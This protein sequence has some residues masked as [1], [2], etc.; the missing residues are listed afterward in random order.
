MN[1]KN[2]VIE[3]AQETMYASTNSGHIHAA[4]SAPALENDDSERVEAKVEQQRLQ[5][6]TLRAFHEISVLAE[7]AT[8]EPSAPLENDLVLPATTPT[9]PSLSPTTSKKLCRL[10]LPQ[11]NSEKSP[12]VARKS[13]NGAIS[14]NVATYS[15]GATDTNVSIL[16][17][18]EEASAAVRNSFSKS[19]LNEQK[20]TLY[21]SLPL[22]EHARDCIVER[23]END[24]NAKYKQLLR[25]NLTRVKLE[26]FVNYEMNLLRTEASQKR[27]EMKMRHIE[28]NKGE[29]YARL[30]RYLFSEYL[31]HMA[32]SSM[33]GL[34]RK[35]DV[36]LK[37]V[38]TLEK[39]RLTMSKRCGDHVAM[40]QQMEFQTAKLETLHLARLKSHLDQLRQLRT[41][42]ASI[43]TSDRAISY[44]QVEQYLTRVLQDPNL[45]AH[46]N[47][48]R[49]CCG[50][51]NGREDLDLVP[52][53]VNFYGGISHGS[54]LAAIVDHLKYCLDV[55]IFFEKKVTLEEEGV[56]SR[57]PQ[58]FYRGELIWQ[59]TQTKGHSSGMERKT[60]CYACGYINGEMKT[61]QWCKRCESCDV[62]LYIPPSSV[63]TKSSEW[64]SSVLRF[65]Q[66]LQKWISI[67]VQSL[68]R[69]TSLQNMPY[70][71]MHVM[72]LPRISTDERSWFLRFF[73]FPRA[74]VR[75]DGSL[76]NEWSEDLVDHYIAMLHLVFHPEK[77]RQMATIVSSK[78]SNATKAANSA[79]IGV[80]DKNGLVSP[81]WVLL[82][83]PTMLDR[84]FLSDEDFVAVLNQFP[85][86]FAFGQ[87]F[88]CTLDVKKSFSRALTL[89]HELT[90]SLRAFQEFEQLPTRIAQL[91]GQLL[92]EAAEVAG[93]GRAT[94]TISKEY[95]LYPTLFDQ[96]VLASL[97]GLMAV[98]CNR[99]AWRSLHLIPFGALSELAKWDVVALLL[100]NLNS[101]PHEAK[102]ASGW[103][104]FV[105]K[106]TSQDV[107]TRALVRQ[108]LY[109]LIDSD[110]ESSLCLLNA[111]ASIAASCTTQT[112][113]D[114]HDLVVVAVHEL[115]M[116]GFTVESCQQALGANG[117]RAAEPLSILCLAHPWVLS[118]LITLLYKFHKCAATWIHIFE[119]FPINRWMPTHQ[120]LV[121]LQEWLLLKDTSAPRSALA[122]FLL[123]HINWEYDVKMQRLFTDA[124]L[125]RQ[126]ALMVAEA[127]VLYKTRKE[128]A[129]DSESVMM[130]SGGISPQKLEVTSI[131]KS[132]RRA[133][134]F[135]ESVDFEKWCWKLMLKLRFYSPKEHEPLLPLIDL[136]HDRTREAL[137]LRRWFAGASVLRVLRSRKVLPFY[138]SH[139]DHIK[140]SGGTDKKEQDTVALESGR[141]T[142]VPI[143][144]ENRLLLTPNN[145]K[146]G[147]SD[148]TVSA[149]VASRT[150]P[151]VAY[152]I[153]QLTTFVFSDR[154]DRWEPLLVLLKSELFDAAI[155]V[156]ENIIPVLSRRGEMKNDLISQPDGSV[157]HSEKNEE[158]A[159]S[160][161]TKTEAGALLSDNAIAVELDYEVEV[162]MAA[163]QALSTDELLSLLDSLH[164]FSYIN[165][166]ELHRM[167]EVLK[168]GYIGG[169][170]ST[171][172]ARILAKL[173]FVRE[174]SRYLHPVVLPA[175]INEC[176]PQSSPVFVTTSALYHGA[177]SW[178][179]ST[180]GGE[181]STGALSPSA[182]SSTS[183][184]LLIRNSSLTATPAP[185]VFLSG[186]DYSMSTTS[187]C[188]FIRRSFEY[189]VD[190]SRLL[191]SMQFWAK[192]L[193]QVPFWYENA[194]FRHVLDVM[195]QCSMEKSFESS[196]LNKSVHDSDKSDLL[197]ELVALI[198]ATFDAF[199]QRIAR[200]EEARDP[201][202]QFLENESVVVMS[203]LPAATTSATFASIFRDTDDVA[204]YIGGCPYLS[205]WILLVETQKEV[206]LFLA[207]GQLMIK[208]EPKTMKKI[209]KMKRVKGKLA[210]A[211]GQYNAVE[212]EEKEQR[213]EALDGTSRLS[214]AFQFSHT[215]MDSL[216]QYKIYRWC[217]YCLDLPESEPLQI[218][219]WQVFFALYFAT[220]GS[221][222]V[223]GHHFLDHTGVRSPKHV[224]LRTCLQM[225]LRK[226]VSYC[227]NQAQVALTATG[228]S[229]HSQT[230]C[231][232]G[233]S[234][235]L[236]E[237][238]Y[239]H[240]VALSQLYTAMDA[241]MEER[242]PNMWLKEDNLTSLPRLY[243][244]ER[245]KEV[246]LLS[247]ALLCNSSHAITWS[248]LR[249]WT[250]LCGFEFTRRR[251]NPTIIGG[252][253]SSADTMAQSLT[254]PLA[255]VGEEDDFSF[256]EEA[257][258]YSKQ[259]H[260]FGGVY[261]LTS[262][263]IR[264]LPLLSDWCSSLCLTKLPTVSVTL[265]KDQCRL[266]PS[267]ALDHVGLNA[268][269]MKFSEN[270]STILALDSEL[271]ESVSQLYVSKA[272]TVMQNVPCH[273]GTQCRS[274]AAFK[275]E[276]LEWMMDPRMDDMILSI[277][278]QG[279]RCDLPSMVRPSEISS[280]SHHGDELHEN[281]DLALPASVTATEFLQLDGKYDVVLM[282]ILLIDQ[283]VRALGMELQRLKKMLEKEALVKT[284]AIEAHVDV[285]EQTRGAAVEEL[286][287]LQK[288]EQELKCLHSKGLE[289]FHLL[290]NLDTKL[291]RSVPSV[292]E[293]LWRSV[294]QLGR[295]FV[296]IDERETC[297]LLQLMLQDPSR[298]HLLSDCFC[299]SAAPS[300]FVEMFAMLMSPSNSSKLSSEQKLTLLYRFDFQTWLQ[301][302]TSQTQFKFDRDTILCI[303]LKDVR[304][305]F[306]ADRNLVE[307]AQKAKDTIVLDHL[308]QVLRVYAKILLVICSAH[309]ADHVETMIRAVVDVQDDYQF[310]SS[311][312]SSGGLLPCSDSR[313]EITESAL[314]ALPRP[315]DAVVWEALG[316][317]PISTWKE[318]AFVQI[319]ACV[320]FL[321][322]HMLT[323][324]WQGGIWSSRRQSTSGEFSRNTKD[325]SSAST[326]ALTTYPLVY[327][328]RLGVLKSLLDLFALF[329][330]VAPE[331]H[332]WS[333]ISLCFEPLLSTL[334]QPATSAEGSASSA[335]WSEHDSVS[336]GTSI[337]SSFVAICSEYLKPS[338]YRSIGSSPSQHNE[339]T[340]TTK[341]SQIWSFYLTALVPHAPMHICKH[342]YQYLTRLAWEHWCLTLEVVQQMCA[343]VQTE[344]QQ[345]SRV[346]IES[347]D[348]IVPPLASRLSPYPFVSWLVRDIL[349][350]TT[351]KATNTWLDAQ[352]ESICS[353]F[354]LAFAKLCIELVLD[355]PHFQLQSGPAVSAN[356]LPPYFMNFM[357]QQAVFWRKW[358][359]TMEDLKDLQQFTLEALKEPIYSRKQSRMG[360]VSTELFPMAPSAATMQDAFTR[361]QLVLRLFGQI[362][363][364]HHEK[365]LY[366]ESLSRVN[367]FVNLL[368]GVYDGGTVRL[369]DNRDSTDHDAW[370]LVLYGATCTALYE[371]LD[372]IAQLDKVEKNVEK[373]D[374]ILNARDVST[375]GSITEE[376]LTIT[377]ASVLRFC[378]LSIVEPFFQQMQ[379]FAGNGQSRGAVSGTTCLNWSKC[380][381][382]VF[383]EIDVLLR[384]YA[385]C[386][387]A[388][389]KPKETALCGDHVAIGGKDVA[390][391]GD[392]RTPSAD[393]IGI[394]LGKI[395]W[396]FLAFRG[397]ELACLAACGRALASVHVMSHVAEKC[398][399]KWI[400]EERRDTWEAL[401]RRLQVPE[402]SSDE[403]EASCLE[404]GNLLTLL[405]LFL[406]QLRRAPVLTESLSLALL[407][408]VMN[409]MARARIDS[410][411]VA[412]MKFLFLTA[413]VTSFV[414]KPLA[415]ILP[416][417]LKKQMLRQLSDLLLESG[418]ARRHNGLMKA[419]G[420]GGALQYGIE[421]HVS[422]LAAGIFLRLQTRS[423][424]PLRVTNRIPLNMTR[425]TAK[426]VHALETM[427]QS[428]D[429]FQLGRRVDGVVLFAGD[430]QRSLA[431]HDEFFVTLFSSTYPS[432]GW[433]LAKCWS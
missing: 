199:C 334:Y 176:F 127:L 382:V 13:M 284:V 213:D 313:D 156:L 346:A 164:E 69:T 227:S 275:F 142:G 299:P 153:C 303:I 218:I 49:S 300:R 81:E 339:L 88:R 423:S 125:H 60:K 231:H 210:A 415:T 229:S 43:H 191:Q 140:R 273:E 259:R 212:N 274:P 84:Y 292:R 378:N 78:P 108:H 51:S 314:T 424:A 219:Y 11:Q 9:A 364:M 386:P 144:H 192:S 225:K 206:P 311:S 119:T 5:T 102:T 298:I 129:S 187:L 255:P 48:M 421:F 159:S 104:R 137:T 174:C 383:V 256:V 353:S 330:R 73:Q 106:P 406:Q 363:A 168:K 401:T 87:V 354:L 36:L 158:A 64:Y 179:S 185:V 1:F 323:I 309:L 101:I 394:Y 374:K 8:D 341:L 136:R 118:L 4:P 150:E 170:E 31:L 114:R 431:D 19:H 162:C 40:E 62:V 92:C 389:A 409:W 422:C 46:V 319:E 30:E 399:E 417:T 310:Q 200:R 34:K 157:T 387:K 124:M 94:A 24:A 181:N 357:I 74:M 297:T 290:T 283:V 253:S 304:V 433:L 79:E 238:K 263:T 220:A 390:K 35:M 67:C 428:K 12:S 169:W 97:N 430:A 379:R 10:A 293:A 282:Q 426:H 148:T 326:G 257:T 266:T 264:P 112:L 44:F 336:T 223:Y 105:G 230:D 224:H 193:L 361:L 321:S 388:F 120:D 145:M 241:W 337:C 96:L 6:S 141:S 110:T 211:L 15:N 77:L 26:P 366:R 163:M 28:T 143:H 152:V 331:H 133:L 288:T 367:L 291:L 93:S 7:V 400:I 349:C 71:L 345:L 407:T 82:E 362:T 381:T 305:Q 377:I 425:T 351:W 333:I 122:R 208:Y 86:T 37:K 348:E 335:P 405:V 25:Q 276:Y 132:I 166:D 308:N 279:E 180:L 173:R 98:E 251:I 54:L 23:V 197:S 365:L 66:S 392:A 414:C 32:A 375:Q 89:V 91:L 265:T 16:V 249:L 258:E 196:L 65:R 403:F 90:N 202:L 198:Q 244:V 318:L 85:N 418:H 14:S 412:Q 261:G 324:R 250:D 350:R 404:H 320:T 190:D 393:A 121:N 338:I 204:Q 410:S 398:I 149:T 372:E 205:F 109:D 385:S 240:Y 126:V 61:H 254:M 332:Q 188:A 50:G 307:T 262:L 246:L 38:W 47:K 427:L 432:Q 80:V 359:M 167:Q 342:I 233:S 395:L 344:K 270:L 52:E 186:G 327:W 29:L 165:T 171:A 368:F 242:D 147:D 260:G 419:I 237:P 420:L 287:P 123:D 271:M 358:K 239:A 195:L 413:K 352:S 135:N 343:L 216:S 68:I 301:S 72:Y 115:F 373:C 215:S 138:R 214:D 278:A 207:M 228:T 267:I 33:E 155:K 139:E 76:C 295:S 252:K 236:K 396:S 59:H 355:M 315:V 370:L 39:K 146:S 296:C 209:E 42:E 416:S 322:Q 55:L 3:N 312:V 217:N 328:Q 226:L 100:F 172:K 95:A 75:T 182:A 45:V 294:K 103:M 347:T 17:T 63:A 113:D 340:P 107:D 175:L 302:K 397:G 329:C 160:D 317:I 57:V 203:F 41:V 201:E 286:T 376:D 281:R 360:I 280:R 184:A 189:S 235:D 369:R 130:L 117:E 134:W 248:Q 18:V 277:R 371:K 222:R 411:P 56:F 221:F 177:I 22:E 316:G 21:P 178:I 183:A 429:A 285:S 116:A 111:V 356:A 128:R 391:T 384:D 83:N 402:L 306:P 2:Q 131:A 243:E 272:R 234:A 247:D 151:I 99:A 27:Q 154:L 20:A 325:A 58:S 268:V 289:W 161:E 408:K 380:G 232:F 194:A 245:L 70:L 269:A 53:G